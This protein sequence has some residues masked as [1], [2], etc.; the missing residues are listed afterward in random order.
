MIALL[1]AGCGCGPAQA[2]APAQSPAP[3]QA[4]AGNAPL[5]RDFQYTGSPL[6]FSWVTDATLEADYVIRACEPGTDHCQDYVELNCL[7]RSFCEV[8]DSASQ[9]VRTNYAMDIQGD[10]RTGQRIYH[11]ADYAAPPDTEFRIYVTRQ[12]LDVVQE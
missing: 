1:I 12:V 10:T 3:I 5:I 2:A 4:A 8:A 11:F 7:G 9:R 6:M